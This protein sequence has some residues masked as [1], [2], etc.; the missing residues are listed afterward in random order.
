MSSQKQTSRL[1][2]N[3]SIEGAGKKVGSPPALP[4]PPAVGH[5]QAGGEA[6]V[7]CSTA[8]GSSSQAACFSVT[9]PFLISL[10]HPRGILLP[11][12]RRGDGG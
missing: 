10:T 3:M 7:G 12:S 4:Q 5:E 6:W 8:P 1:C 11:L 9:F 2:A